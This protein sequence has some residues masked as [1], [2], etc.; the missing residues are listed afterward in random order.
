MDRLAADDVWTTWGSDLLAY[1]SMLAGPDDAADVVQEVLARVLASGR[2]VERPYL[3]R[4]V[5]NEV[6]AQH[7]SR[8]R[9]ERREWR[10]AELP[11]HVE[12]LGD[13][14]VR[15]ALG[16]LSPMQRAVVF[17]TYWEDLPPGEVGRLLGI[18]PGTAKAHLARARSALRKVL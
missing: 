8:S 1:A 11:G 10:A 14:D 3:F 17:L 6:R 18:A 16:R 13:P 7:R 4:S 15:A 12:V 5:L 9:R 2:V